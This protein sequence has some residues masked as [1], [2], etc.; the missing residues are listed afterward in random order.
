MRGGE[1]EDVEGGKDAG[2][3]CVSAGED[4]E[5]GEQFEGVKD[6]RGLLVKKWEISRKGAKAQR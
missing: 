6:A 3:V 5:G 2:R 4:V 1:I